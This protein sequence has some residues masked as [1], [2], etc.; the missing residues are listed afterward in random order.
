MAR[1][2]EKAQ[3]MLSRYLRTKQEAS[4][5]RQR[6]PYLSTLC[7]DVDEAEKWRLQVL[8]D[9]RRL[10]EEIQ[11]PGLDDDRVQ[12]LND[13]INKLLRERGHWERRIRYLGGKDYGRRKV[14]LSDGTVLEH[15]GYFYFGEAKRLPGVQELLAAKE[16]RR[17]ERLDDE[18]LQRRMTEMYA[19]VDREYYGH[20]DG[21]DPE[22][23]SIENKAEKDARAKLVA[24]W[25]EQ[26]NATKDEPW[27]DGYLQFVGKK[28]Q[29]EF[30]QQGSMEAIILERKKL[31]ALEQ[32]QM[33]VLDA[34]KKRATGD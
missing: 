32:L 9:I 5:T 31:E 20:A 17:K 6:R 18:S 13:N 12:E 19:R 16:Q 23:E 11:N 30:G 27:D 34:Q 15:N 29:G 2:E 3:S 26:N 14:D 25:E 28:P 21:N 8:S 1:N 33:G 7:D 22:L 24:A 4:G 10:A